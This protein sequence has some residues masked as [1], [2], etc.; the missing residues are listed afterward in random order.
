MRSGPARIRKVRTISIPEIWPEKRPEMRSKLTKTAARHRVNTKKNPPV[1]VGPFTTSG[2]ERAQS[3]AD[4]RRTATPSKRVSSARAAALSLKRAQGMRRLTRSRTYV[5]P[6][7]KLACSTALAPGD[8][9]PRSDAT[10]RRMPNEHRAC[11]VRWR[12]RPS[13]TLH[14]D[15]QLARRGRRLRQIDLQRA[16][17][18]G[19][20]PIPPRQGSRCYPALRPRLVS[21]A[22]PPLFARILTVAPIDDD[23]DRD[24]TEIKS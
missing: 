20:R 22:R 24:D 3:L 5:P 4:V 21:P 19:A 9:A 17:G 2:P 14:S 12:F 6:I 23:Q 7:K 15:E 13:L 10:C 16:L 11:S 8:C 18:P 1:R